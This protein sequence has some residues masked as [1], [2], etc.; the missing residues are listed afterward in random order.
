MATSADAGMVRIQAHRIRVATPHRTAESRRVAPTPMIAPEIV[1]VV[2]TGMPLNDAPR[3]EIAAAA[4]AQK[5]P[6]GCSLVIR[7]PIVFTIP[8]HTSTRAPA[9]ASAAPTNPPMRAWDDDTGSP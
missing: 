2:E 9:A 8:D 5:P 6:T 3:R 1:W 4:S 7:I